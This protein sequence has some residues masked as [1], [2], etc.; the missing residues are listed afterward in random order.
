MQWTLILFFL[1][2]FDG[3]FSDGCYHVYLD[4][5]SNV[6]VQVRKLFQPDLYPGSG[7]SR[8]FREFFGGVRERDAGKI[9]AIG[10]EP[11]PGH[12]NRLKGSCV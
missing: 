8:I 9:C 3:P 2:F 1:N 10:F 12:E 5:G 11:N 4:V 7:I 6:G